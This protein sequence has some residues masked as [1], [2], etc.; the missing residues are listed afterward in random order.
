MEGTPQKPMLA[1]PGELAI[2]FIGHAS[3]LLQIGGLNIL[4]DPVFAK[5]LV[6]IRRL[7]RPG[8]RLQDLPPIDAV[9]LTHAHMDHLNLP[10]LRAIIR[11][12][13]RLRGTAPIVVVPD[14]VEDLVSMLGFADVRPLRWWGR[15][16]A[17]AVEITMAPA[18]HWGARMMRDTHR[19]FGGYVLRYGEQSVYHSGDSG[20]FAGF[21]EI[22]E[23]LRPEIALLPIG[24]YK[25]DG[26]RRVHTSPE[27]ALRAFADLRAQEMVPMHYGTFRL[28]HEPMEEPLSR[29]ME[30]AGR[31]GVS[32][33]V[34]PL[35]EGETRIFAR[36]GIL[37]RAER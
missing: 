13:R 9:L 17:G 11:H 32:D 29:L 18:Q 33:R 35:S 22:G 16:N 15:A 34:V 23:R 21:R 10:S 4:I 1:A 20:Y 5:W 14:G 19:G 26:F 3:F 24:A 8:V 12:T 25:P 37:E 6:L 31:G 27:D 7:R 28:S 30:A 2:T 36:A